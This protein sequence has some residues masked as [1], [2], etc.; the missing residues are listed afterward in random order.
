MVSQTLGHYRII[1]KIGA[2]GMGEVYRAH[3]ERL[4]RDVAIKILPAGTLGDE[5]ARK[6]FRREALALAKLNH[7]NIA[8]IYDFDTHDEVDFLVTEYIPGITLS[9][10]LASG[11]LPLPQKEVALLGGQLAEGLTAAHDQQVVHRDLKPS[12][13][14]VTP[15]GRLKVLDFGLAK[16]LPPAVILPKHAA[17]RKRK[18]F[19]A[20]CLTCHPINCPVNRPMP[21]ATS[22][23]PARC[24]TKWRPDSGHSANSL[25]RALPTPSCTSHRCRP[26]R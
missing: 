2:G 24:S 10:R 15:D 20:L 14:R 7:P 16:L 12:N 17:F 21:G 23:A 25:P 19:P 26:A 9:D 13:L 22:T 4:E 3:D 1:E 18:E 5:V 6:R 8:T 11:P